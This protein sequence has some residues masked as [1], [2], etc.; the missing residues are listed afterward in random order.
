LLGAAPGAIS[1]ISVSGSVSGA[2]PGHLVAFSQG[3]GAAFVPSSPF[4]AGESVT[5]RGSITTGT[6]TVP[7][8]YGFTVARPDNLLYGYSPL[9]HPEPTEEQHF[10]S[11]PDLTPPLLVV[12]ARSSLTSPGELFAAP[13]AGHG[14]S[15][16]M[17]F[18]EA[19]NVVWF[20]PLPPHIEGANLQVQQYEGA[21]ALTWW[22][23]RITPQ[24]FGQGEEIIDNSS[25][26]QIGAV[27][28][29]NGYLADLH[30]F[31]LRPNGTALLTV[32]HPV[33]CNLSRY[34]GA[35]VGAA[36]DSIFQEVD[37]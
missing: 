19:G 16:P 22:Q 14:P 31:V 1:A 13:Y 25:Y 30:E 36:T 21:P 3:D 24:G 37:I 29:G 17:I 8:S 26:Q 5:V 4:Q 7:F 15:G 2:H 34:G 27:H 23:G 12:S 20:H 32:L 9:L 10:H 28:A 35:A 11:R 18:D 33:E 6:G